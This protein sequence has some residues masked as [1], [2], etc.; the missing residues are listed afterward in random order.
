MKRLLLCS[1]LIIMAAGSLAVVAQSG[2]K[3]MTRVKDINGLEYEIIREGSGAS[4][5]ARQAVKVHYTGW[6]NVNG[7]CGPEF[8]SS[9]RRNT[10]FTFI[11]GIGAVIKGW[12]LGVATMK[13]GEKRRLYI[14]AS[15]GYG[16]YGSGPI[17]ANA[18]LIF[19]VELLSIAD[20]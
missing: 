9:V 1:A 2:K 17:P 18:S 11:I 16:E 4:P 10:P 19:D 5:R 3:Q 14:P 7:Q 13:V 15:L 6:L 8:D 12:D 20:N